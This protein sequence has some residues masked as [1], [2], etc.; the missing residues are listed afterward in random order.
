LASAPEEREEIKKI[1]TKG[2]EE[3]GAACFG[4]G[5]GKNEGQKLLGD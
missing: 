4:L 2:R 3:E 1:T 5:D